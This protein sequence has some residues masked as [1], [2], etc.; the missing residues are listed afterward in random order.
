VRLASRELSS[1]QHRL[2]TPFTAIPYRVHATNHRF[3]ES[4]GRSRGFKFALV[5]GLAA[6]LAK[7]H[8]VIVP[9]S[10]QGA[11]GPT[12][13]PVGQTY[14]DFRC[15]PLFAR[16]M[17]RLLHALLEYDVKF[18]FPQIWKTKGE[19]L[20]QFM[21]VPGVDNVSWQ[22]TRSCWQSNRQV[23]VNGR[24]RQC[25]ICAACMLRRLAVHAAG[26]SEPLDTYFW[27][28]LG[29][30]ELEDG[31]AKSFRRWKITSAM[32]EHAIGGTLYVDHLAEVRASSENRAAVDQ[33][34]F[35]LSSC[36]GLS[37][38]T[39]RARLNRLLSRHESEWRSFLHSLGQRSFIKEWVGLR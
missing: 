22:F 5:S 36:L 21:R 4:S 28:N 32:R 20:A 6:Y 17:S 13:I 3:V 9:E 39:V 16:R 18:E 30:S 38:T 1:K 11:L 19:T 10:G 31:V 14:T 26:L 2:E 23:S 8:T 35:H 15:H 33:N 29:V 27:E 12:L 24:R 37:E 7:A 25:G 34:I